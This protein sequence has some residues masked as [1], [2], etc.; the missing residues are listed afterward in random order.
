MQSPIPIPDFSL[1]C[2]SE[3]VSRVECNY[4]E[5]QTLAGYITNQIPH[6][7]DSILIYDARYLYEHRGGKIFGARR[8]QSF[9]DIE[10]EFKRNNGKN[11]CI[12][13]HC[14]YSMNRG[15]CLYEKF[16]EYDRT[17]NKYPELT[18]PELYVLRGGYKNFYEKYPYLCQGGYVQMRDELY[19]K[20]GDMRQSHSEFKNCFSSKTSKIIKKCHSQGNLQLMTD[21]PK[22]EH[23]PLSTPVVAEA[24]CFSM[25]QGI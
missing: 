22:I 4:I 9:E 15:P 16:R 10:Y 24:P 13:V 7:Y 21:F 18:Y 14:E 8:I 2:P 25:S 19:V 20:N 17:Q 6:Q 12:V 1:C 11:V 23:S 5:A 3:V